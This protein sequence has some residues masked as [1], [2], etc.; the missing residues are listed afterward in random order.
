MV[1][2]IRR[3]EAGIA[4]FF[5]LWILALLSVIVGEFCHTMRVEVNMT[6]D[7]SY[8]T[9]AYYAAYAGIERA[10]REIVKS[11]VFP[12]APQE[13]AASE[14]EEKIQWRVNVRIPPLQLGDASYEVRI[15]NESGKVNINT[16]DGQLLRM[17]LSSFDLD[18]HEKDVIVDSILDWRDQDNLH[19][20]NGAENDYYE[21]LPRPYKCKNGDF[22][23]IDELLL[24][25]G[26]T[27][28]IFSGGLKDMVTVFGSGIPK[29]KVEPITKINVNAASP[30]MLAS[31]PMMSAD[32]VKDIET[33]RKEKD[34]TSMSEVGTI[35]GPT[36]LQAAMRYLT[37]QLGPYYTIRSTGFARDR[38]A[39]SSL[40]TVIKIDNRSPNHYQMLKWDDSAKMVPN[41][42]PETLQP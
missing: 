7:F 30:A 15:E 10:I 2:R 21:Q 42:E 23:T 25:R 9:K 36:V 34:F 35:V 27:E 1:S 22:D 40:S 41:P 39:V 18:D 38:T 6:G 13:L 12:A 19:R 24:V 33:F 11:K 14:G 5:V 32:M 4:L 8:R 28:K 17:L 26:M 31:L 29:K 37:V 3:D 20:L 16:A